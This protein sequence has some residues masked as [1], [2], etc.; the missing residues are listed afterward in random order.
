M[1][2]SRFPI[3]GIIHNLAR[4]FPEVVGAA[5]TNTI[6]RLAGRLAVVF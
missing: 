1:L 3:I 4:R 5:H 2:S 6:D